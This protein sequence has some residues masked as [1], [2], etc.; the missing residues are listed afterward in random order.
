MVDSKAGG[1]IQ[2]YLNP[3]VGESQVSEALGRGE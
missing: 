2:G 3:D 1:G